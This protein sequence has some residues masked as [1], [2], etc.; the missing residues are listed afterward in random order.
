MHQW[1]EMKG[2]AT[3][4]D[5]LGV[6]L[7]SHEGMPHQQLKF[8]P[9]GW[10]FPLVQHAQMVLVTCLMVQIVAMQQSQLTTTLQGQ[11][12]SGWCGLE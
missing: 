3:M 8:F 10:F 6:K 1:M 4:I 12:K 11:R 5:Q 9:G 7:E 2:E